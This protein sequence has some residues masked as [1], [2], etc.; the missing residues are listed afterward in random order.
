MP[1]VSRWFIKS[2]LIC[3]GLA[4][5]AGIIEVLPGEA[6]G[7]PAIVLRPVYYHLFLVGW[8]TQMIIGVSIWFFPRHTRERPRG[9]AGLSWAIFVFLNFGLL[10]RAIF[11]PI[12]AGSRSLWPGALLVLSAVF[13]WLAGVLYIGMIWPRV[14]AKEPAATKRRS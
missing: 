6:A 13:Q 1:T 7:V 5:A 12:A 4:L 10:L 2:S 11:E 3:L 9:P 14:K 8:V